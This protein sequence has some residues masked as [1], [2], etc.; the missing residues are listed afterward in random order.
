M[1]RPRRRASLL[2]VPT[3]PLR[4]LLIAALLLGACVGRLT[5]EHERLLGLYDA[6]L[7]PR[8]ALEARAIEEGRRMLGDVLGDGFTFPE[9]LEALHWN[10]L[11]HAGRATP[12]L[13]P[14]AREAVRRWER[15]VF[16]DPPA[17]GR[18]RSNLLAPLVDRYPDLLRCL[19]ERG[20]PV[21]APR[22]A[23]AR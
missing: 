12:E 22:A 2:V 13:S 11:L 4:T 23:L 20:A 1:T 19:A 3:R 21:P 6:C 17:I 10:A 5:P 9:S 14:R 16:L 7:R 18:R 8:E 15:P